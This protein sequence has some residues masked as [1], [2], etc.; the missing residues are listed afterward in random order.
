MINKRNAFIFLV[1]LL[2][3]FFSPVRYITD[4]R[5][6]L[7]T[8]WAMVHQ[9]NLQLDRFSPL[10]EENKFYAIEE[11]NHHL[12]YTF[13]M[14]TS[15][16][17]APFLAI[18]ELFAKHVYYTDTLPL[19]TGNYSG[20]IEAF[21]AALFVAFS[22]VLLFNLLHRLKVE[23]W[24][25]WFTVIVFAFGTSAWSTASR[26]LFAHGSSMVVLLVG[27]WCLLKAE[28]NIRWLFLA[29]FCFAFSFTI[30]PTNA[31]SLLIFGLYT[32]WKYRW[33]VW[34][35]ATACFVVLIPFFLYNHHVY[36]TF[37][38]NYYLPSRIGED[39]NFWKGLAG[40]FISPSRGLFFTSPVFL[41]SIPL[42][43]CQITKKQFNGFY[44][45][46]L[47]TVLLHIYLISTFT[48]WYAGWS[49]GGRYWCEIIPYLMVLLAFGMQ[50]MFDTGRAKTKNILLSMFIILSGFSFYINCQGA[51][52]PKTLE[53][54]YIPNN[55]DQHRDRVWDWN[56]IQF[57][58]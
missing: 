42:V 34:P 43:V 50:S 44:F 15:I 6:T 49:F 54:N 7:H 25:V 29:G 24:L 47:L 28:I 14:G 41:L 33:Q 30:R 32:L 51:T 39:G 12:Y 5:W 31:I 45:A 38:S 16:M 19:L 55:V 9:H 20:G 37:L 58:R 23:T 57:L 56:D 4:S 27:L 8:A 11:Y 17:C 52:N 3:H 2:T 35:F 13:P 21:L 48:T 18:F 46:I 36:G 53:W 40:N 10:I 26:G 22:A 1:V